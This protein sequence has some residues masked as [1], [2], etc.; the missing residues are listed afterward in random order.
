MNKT[1]TLLPPLCC[2]LAAC[3]ATPKAG[4]AGPPSESVIPNCPPGETANRCPS[5]PDGTPIPSKRNKI[6]IVV[7]AH[8]VKAQPPVVCTSAGEEITVT[9]V[10]IPTDEDVIAATVPKDGEHGWILSMRTGDGTMSIQVPA[11][12]DEGDY[13]YFAMTSSGKCQDPKIHVD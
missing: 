2:L 7:S 5:L 11:S 4:P 6:K 1:L 13:G 10:G 3:P 8:D 12:T 9:V